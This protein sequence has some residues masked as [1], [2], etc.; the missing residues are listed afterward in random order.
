MFGIHQQEH[1]RKQGQSKE[2]GEGQSG[3]YKEEA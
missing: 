3:K 1:N 2:K